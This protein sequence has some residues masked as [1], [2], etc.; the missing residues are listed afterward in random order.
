[1]TIP[2]PACKK[3][4]KVAGTPVKEIGKPT[5]MVIHYGFCGH[6]FQVERKE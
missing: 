4:N 6:R 5:V 1:M 2:C 3:L